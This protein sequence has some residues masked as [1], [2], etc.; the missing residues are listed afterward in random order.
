MFPCIISQGWGRILQFCSLVFAI[1]CIADALIGHD[2]ESPPKGRQ[3]PS[4]EH[5]SLR[6]ICRHAHL[7]R[8][9]RFARAL[10]PSLCTPPR[11]SHTP[12]F[13]SAMEISS[14]AILRANPPRPLPL[15]RR[16]HAASNIHIIAC[17]RRCRISRGMGI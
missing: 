4:K 10:T 8:K 9:A 12:L 15:V 3:T 16:L 7:L 1:T 5:A 6:T 2:I 17:R 14:S 11:R 13:P